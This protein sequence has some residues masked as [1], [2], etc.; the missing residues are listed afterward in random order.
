MWPDG[1]CA[2]KIRYCHI[3]DMIMAGYIL[4]VPLMFVGCGKIQEKAEKAVDESKKK[5]MDEGRTFK[6]KLQKITVDQYERVDSLVR[7]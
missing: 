3:I 6:N 2:M 4:C 5:V 1:G 7:Q